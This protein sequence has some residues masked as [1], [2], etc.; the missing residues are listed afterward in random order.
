MAEINNVASLVNDLKDK[1]EEIN[2]ACC[3]A[4]DEARDR[5]ND[6]K[7]KANSILIQAVNRITDSS[8]EYAESE[9]VEKSLEIVRDKSQ[10][11]FD[12]AL[13]RIKEIKK[14]YP[15]KT[16]NQDINTKIDDYLNNQ[17]TNEVIDTSDF[18]R[19]ELSEK[20]VQI[21]REWLKTEDK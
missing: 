19:D 21:L 4:S 1:I 13:S 11:L 3:N 6:I 16:N 14:Q 7:S 9:D 2:A 10:E 12:N 8:L 15:I 18:V 17:E 20:A 5:I